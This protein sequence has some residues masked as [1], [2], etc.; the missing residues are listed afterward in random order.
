MLERSDTDNNSKGLLKNKTVAVKRVDM[1]VLSPESILAIKNEMRLLRYE[2]NP[3]FLNLE[4]T[5]NQLINQDTPIY[6]LKL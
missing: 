1:E 3:D 6:M 4:P 5:V 2:T